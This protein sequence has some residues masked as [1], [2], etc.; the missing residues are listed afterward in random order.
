MLV[1]KVEDVEGNVVWEP[2]IE[3][4]LV[5]APET[6][7]DLRKM[8]MATV[9]AGTARRPFR[10]LPASLRELEIGG[11]TGSITG[12]EPFGKRD[13]FVAYSRDPKR[14]DDRGV[15]L[16][17]MIVNKKRWYVKSAQVAREIFELLWGTS[18]HSSNLRRMI[19]N[20]RT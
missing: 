19:W 20:S 13:W 15:S 9:E 7:E 8:M 17:V 12:G 14:P 4:E 18:R 3:Q 5:I 1:N 10:R 2:T 16:C 11:K 6:S